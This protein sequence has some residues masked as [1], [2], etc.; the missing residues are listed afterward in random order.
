MM[1]LITLLFFNFQTQAQMKSSLYKKKEIPAATSQNR[2][3]EAPIKS[4]GPKALIGNLPGYHLN[5][6]RYNSEVNPV[7]LPQK[8]QSIANSQILLGEV[9]KADIL[10]SLIA[11]A[12][13]KAPIRAKI[14]SGKLKGSIILGEATLEK[15]SKRILI[16]FNRLRTFQNSTIWQ[17]NAQALDS[18]GILGIEGE[19]ISGEA[20]YF[21]AEFLAAAA[22][23]Y[24]DATVIRETTALGGYV[25]KPG[26]D[27]YTKKALASALSK[28]TDRFSEKFKSAP[29][30]SVLKGPFEIQVVLIEQPKLLE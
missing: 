2:K 15:N 20:K 14:S 3:I 17:L 21:G 4:N 6:R 9:V 5:K 23:G 30:Y 1:S 8:N 25:E 29:E 16:T 7:L 12:D 28:T 18:D 13:S 22:A 10:E 24:A 19:Y 26:A 27:T 11:F